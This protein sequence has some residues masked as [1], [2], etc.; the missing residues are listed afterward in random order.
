MSSFTA[1][2]QTTTVLDLEKRLKVADKL[3]GN[4]AV[5]G[6]NAN[7]GAKSG[8]NTLRPARV[9]P[10]GAIAVLVGFFSCG[11][12]GAVAS[13]SFSPV[14]GAAKQSERIGES[15]ADCPAVNRTPAATLSPVFVPAAV[16]VVQLQDD[17]IVLAAAATT[18][19]VARKRGFTNLPFA[20]DFFLPA[21]G[22]GR[23][24]QGERGQAPGASPS[25]DT[26]RPS[27]RPSA[28][29]PLAVPSSGDGVAATRGAQPGIPPALTNH[30]LRFDAACGSTMT[31]RHAIP[32]PGWCVQ[33]SGDAR[34]IARR[35]YFTAALS[36]LPSQRGAI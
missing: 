30:P 36:L 19:A 24:L 13:S 28:F 25:G 1:G 21:F 6:T 20:D 23:L 22:A 18:A 34:N 4:S 15:V 27:G 35:R 29:A 3:A 11:S 17:E 8:W 12:V 5:E 7:G 2:D 9:V 26:P 32:Q 14:A 33:A 31:A 16:N 10:P